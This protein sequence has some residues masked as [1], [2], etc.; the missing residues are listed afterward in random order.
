MGWQVLIAISILCDAMGRI[1]QRTIM[2]GDSSDPIANA[3]LYQIVAGILILLYAVITG[4]S[5]PSN[6]FEIWPNLVFV[7]LLWGISNILIFKSLKTTEASV[8][9]ILF[10]TRVVWIILLAL[11]LLG[12]SF[13][14]QQIIGTAFIL[15]SVL[16][17][18][19]KKKKLTLG[20][21]EIL[22]LLAAI[23]FGTAIINDSFIIQTF[24]VES[25]L[26][27]NFLSS[28]LFI[29][30]FNPHATSEIGKI[31]STSKIRN[32]TLLG[33]IY[34]FSSVTYFLAYKLSNNASQIGAIYPVSAILTVIF[35]IFLLREKENLV[36]KIIAI[37]I[38]F[39]GVLLVG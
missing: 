33:I 22:A 17:V 5:L 3:I 6:L 19:G 1:V 32:I 2:K 16:F 38:S 11:L 30:I 7:P 15:F 18:S 27:L 28:A 26:S 20:K 39:V 13:S 14:I 24:D 31:M 34:G 21:G 12:E 10:T 25:Y 8:F 9:T 37:G 4:F 35:A 36:K 29:W 23:S